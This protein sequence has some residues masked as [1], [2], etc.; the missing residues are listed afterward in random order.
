MSRKSYSA[1]LDEVLKPAGFTRD[2]RW[3]SRTVGSVLEQVD[4][5]TSSIAGTTANLWSKDLETA[6]VLKSI[7]CEAP[8]DIVQFGER[9]GHL[10]NGYDR[11]WR[12]D[13]NG[14]SQLADAVRVHGLPWFDSVRSLDDQ[15]RR[16]GRGNSQ[17]WRTANLPALAVTLYRLG[18]FDE[19]FTLFEASV[20]K[21]AI[22]GLIARGRC[23]QRW[24]EAKKHD[25]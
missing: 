8:L 25:D 19:A 4:L 15:A 5:Q 9:I 13:P 11:W 16:F 17:P 20:P 7:E 10:I 3:W 22:P 14:P 6:R 18:A 23:V 21:T 1:A 24:L 2:G 12:N